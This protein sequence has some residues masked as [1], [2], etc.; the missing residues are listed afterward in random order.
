[1]D[2]THT[3]ALLSLLN[4]SELTALGKFLKSPFFTAKK[5]LA[6]LFAELREAEH[7]VLQSPQDVFPRLFD[8]EAFD[9]HKWN[10]ALSDLNGCIR[11]FL[12]IQQFQSDAHLRAKAEV[13]AFLGRDNAQAFKRAVKAAL[14]YS[15]DDGTL[16]TADGWQLRFWTLKQSA[17][18]ALADR[19]KSVGQLLDD[20]DESVDLYYFISKLQLACIRAS[21]TQVLNIKSNQAD[22][23]QLLEQTEQ[24]D[25]LGK[26]ALLSLYRALLRLLTAPN[27]QFEPFFALL[28]HQGPRLGRG[29]LEP[30]VRLVLNRCI[31][32]Y[33]AGDLK[34]FDQY[35]RM[36]D[37]TD[38]QNSWTALS[39][40]EDFFLNDGVMFAKSQD[41][42]GFN[43]FLEK[44]KKTLP[45]KR[46]NKTV[47]LLEAYGHFYSGEFREAAILLNRLD[48]RHPRFSMRFHSLKARNTYEEWRCSQAAKEELVNALRS[49]EE[50]LRR[51][52]SLFATP[53]RQSYRSLI[54][55]IQKLM[56]YG[57]KRALSK[58][59]LQAELQKRQPVAGDWVAA[60]IDEL[61]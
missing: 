8:G 37:W 33:R 55:F 42:E 10:K 5:H 46:R 31:Q 6:L 39:K 44:G 11:D 50:F 26:S 3:A 25:Q 24:L 43:E 17:S 14:R 45:G 61:P 59:Q 47:V 52:G 21:S 41:K 12:A 49:F 22:Y 29:E 9:G 23:Q 16:E 56:R 48:S 58:K 30:V 27:T 51:N 1:M 28:Q 54:W 32:R 15:N 7:W 35:R 60:K 2:N 40:G 18:Y 20:M 4:K 57:E 13:N 38:K 53:L 34:A 19:M 36:F